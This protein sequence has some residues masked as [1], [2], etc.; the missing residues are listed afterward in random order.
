MSTYSIS[1]FNASPYKIKI[2]KEVESIIRLLENSQFDQLDNRESIPGRGVIEK[3]TDKPNLMRIF[4][5]W[6]T[7]YCDGYFPGAGSY[8][9]DGITTE[10]LDIYHEYGF[11]SCNFYQSDVSK[12]IWD[13]AF[14]IGYITKEEYESGAA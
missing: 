1:S 3:L 8:H 6:F 10:I 2:D 14:E 13:H 12:D 9:Y 4:F 7:K 11:H 5:K